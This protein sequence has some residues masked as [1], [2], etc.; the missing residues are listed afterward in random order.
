LKILKGTDATTG[1][2]TWYYIEYRQ[3][4]GFD[5]ILNGVGNL[6]SGVEIRTGTEQ[7]GGSYLLDMTPNT[8][9]Y[10]DLDDGAL[11]LGSS[12]NDTAAGVTI[13]T[14]WA[15]GTGAG[16]N[17]TLAQPCVRAQPSV[18][19]SPAQSSSIAGT[20]ILYTVGVT[21]NDS[22]VCSSSIFNLQTSLPA[23]WSGTLAAPVLGVNAGSNSSTTLTVTSPT[24]AAPGSYTI[25][26]AATNGSNSV[27]SGTASLTHSVV[28]TL[29]DA[30]WTDK[31]SYVKGDT[32]TITASATAAGQPVANASVTLTVT[33]PNGAIVAQTV[34]TKANGQAVYRLR[35]SKRD[36]AGMYMVLAGATSNGQTAMASTSFTVQ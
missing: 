18:L 34:S 11:A 15:N 8:S 3:P 32:I 9:V 17:V 7:S 29:S 23:G 14:Q 10:S 20:P 12:F 1:L 26:A 22:S 28:A 30:V 4:L 21:N 35:L 36:P 27:F 19:I 13:T 5:N 16:V 31:S 24:S 2:K 25:T 33:K 6:V